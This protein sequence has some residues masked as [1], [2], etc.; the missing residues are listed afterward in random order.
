MSD[1]SSLWNPV[2]V[3]TMLS[4]G[5]MI[6]KPIHVLSSGLEVAMATKTSSRVQRAAEKPA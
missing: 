1:V 5:T 2:R 4:D 3:G 6:G